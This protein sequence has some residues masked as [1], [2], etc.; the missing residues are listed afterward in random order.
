MTEEQ[1]EI[2]P[3]A[4]LQKSLKQT[5]RTHHTQFLVKWTH[6]PVEDATW[7]MEY[8]LRKNY[9]DFMAKWEGRTVRDDIAST[10]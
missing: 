9:P 7:V 2:V 10:S 6:M 4:L 8:E 3:E 1:L 5:R